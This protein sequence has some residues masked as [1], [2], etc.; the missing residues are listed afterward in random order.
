MPTGDLLAVPILIDDVAVAFVMAGE[1]AAQH[2][3][4]GAGAEGLGDV[5]GTGAAAVGAD[6]T[7]KP[8]RGVGAFDDGGEL[9][10]A[11]AGHPPR[12]ADR[13]RADADLDDVGA[14]DDQRLGHVPGDDV[15]GHDHRL[16]MVIA[17]PFHGLQELLGVTVGDV[18][19]DHPDA[20]GLGDGGK[21]PH[22]GRGG[23]ERIEGVR[24]VRSGEEFCQLGLGI[25]LVQGGQRAMFGRAPAPSPWSRSRPYWRR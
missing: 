20:R 6:L 12:G 10:I 19:A 8:V 21:L 17:H 5:A 16:G 22:V 18:Q 11:D 3:E 14:S 4:I 23:A 2:D 25:V 7:F 9:G 24:A 15:A 13:A 1:H